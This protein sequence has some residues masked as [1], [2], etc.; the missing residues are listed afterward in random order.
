MIIVTSGGAYTDIDAYAACIAYAELLRRHGHDSRAVLEPALNVS[1]TPYLRGLQA[2]FH[3][4]YSP[5]A[6]DTYVLIDISDGQFFAPFVV[7]E[8]ITEVIDHHPGFEKYW[9]SEPHVKAQIEI[10]GA[11]CTQ[12]V[13]RWVES[14]ELPS[15]PVEIAQLL[16]AGILDNT[17]GLKARITTERDMNAY[18]KLQALIGDRGSFIEAY[19]EDCQKSIEHDIVAA[20]RNDTKTL[21]FPAFGILTVGQLAVW[22]GSEVLGN[23]LED[24]RTGLGG[25]AWLCNIISIGEGKSSLVANGENVECY[26]AELLGVTFD[27][28]GVAPATRLWLRKEIMKAAI[29]K[30]GEIA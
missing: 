23:H 24:I 4:T 13:E 9:A 11:T 28:R 22:D 5:N 18:E 1:V 7:H 20:I 30:H 27:E 8:R 15:M 10:V 14:G 29:E 26:F 3:R 12:I 21:T 16:M 17:L 2:D 19:F 6:A 25:D